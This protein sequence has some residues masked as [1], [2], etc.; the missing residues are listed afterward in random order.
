MTHLKFVG[1]RKII[2]KE[3]KGPHIWGSSFLFISRKENV[4]H[5]YLFHAKGAKLN[6]RKGRIK[7]DINKKS[8]FIDKGIDSWRK[9]Y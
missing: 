1:H 8:I 5:F 6:A 9:R 7:N 3:F 2:F 4:L